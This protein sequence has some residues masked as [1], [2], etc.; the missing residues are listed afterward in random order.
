LFVYSEGA[1][2]HYT[3]KLDRV[4]DR[5]SYDLQVPENYQVNK[6]R[7]TLVLP[8]DTIG[9]R[10]RYIDGSQSDNRHR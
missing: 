1:E 4:P 6:V 8:L 2:V 10:V 9:N 3:V 7:P 5:G